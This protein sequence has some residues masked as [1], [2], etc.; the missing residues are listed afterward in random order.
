MIELTVCIATYNRAR[1]LP[2]LFAALAEQKVPPDLAWEVVIVDNNSRDDTA[3]AIE[4]LAPTLPVPVR[5]V[6]E[7][8]QGM[9]HARNRGIVESRG[10]M[11]GILDDDVLPAPDW[12]ATLV[13]L[14]EELHADG[15]GGQILPA[16]ESP[17]PAW[18]RNDSRLQEH[19]FALMRHPER[20]ELSYPMEG[21]GQIWGS[22]MAFRKALFDEIGLFDTQHGRGGG[23]LYKGNEEL[24]FI[25]KALQRGRRLVYDPSLI[26]HHRI[27]ADRTRKAYLRKF[28]F[29]QGESDVLLQAVTHDDD[30][31]TQA[32]RWL[33]RR[34]FE[35]L[36][37]WIRREVVGADDAFER[38]REFRYDLGLLSGYRKARNVRGRTT[39]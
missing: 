25:N 39:R 20:R 15:L 26:V 4:R 22:N 33:Y 24:R 3:A 8:E 19:C 10:A 36:L 17:P 11:I 32:P 7:T 29:D 14:A 31:A 16:W 2:G 35:R 9:S 27:G 18:L 30:A 6:L 21:A 5:Q 37:R 34:A 28:V 13:R 1:L 38:E 12:V 23:K